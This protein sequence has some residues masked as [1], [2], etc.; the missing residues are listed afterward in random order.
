MA[1]IHISE[2]SKVYRG[3]KGRR[4]QALTG[5]NLEVQQGEVLGF[6]GPNGAGKSYNFV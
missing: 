2:L 3:K 1:P 4:V 5:L 6:L